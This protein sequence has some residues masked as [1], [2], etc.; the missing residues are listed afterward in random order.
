MAPG[1]F[2][3]C[4][5]SF[6]RT[7][8]H[9]QTQTGRLSRAPGNREPR[10]GRRVHGPQLRP[11]FGELRQRGL[12]HV[13]SRDLPRKG[14][15]DRNLRRSIHSACERQEGRDP[16][17]KGIHG[18]HVV[19]VCRLGA[20]CPARWGFRTRNHQCAFP[21]RTT[22]SRR[23][24]A[25]PF[26]PAQASPGSNGFLCY[27]TRTC[28]PVGV[29]EGSCP[30]GKGAQIPGRR[31]SLLPLP[32]ESQ[33]HTIAR[34]PLYNRLGINHSPAAIVRV[35]SVCLPPRSLP[36]IGTRPRSPASATP[37]QSECRRN[38]PGN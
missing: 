8:P 36:D 3:D 30:G 6:S 29:V 9:S 16:S 38:A 22:I 32:R 4:W 28:S 34:T 11:R 27:A 15:A 24:R 1:N 25:R 37:L 31:I 19:E 2:L 20:A 10:H 12:P 17:R 14:Q 23:Q 18:C 7:R 5:A 33:I 21:V 26:T 35:R 13:R